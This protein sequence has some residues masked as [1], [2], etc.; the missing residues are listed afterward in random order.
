MNNSGPRY[1]CSLLE[2][3]L[4]TDILWCV[5]LLFVMCL[6][7]AIGSHHQQIIH[8]TAAPIESEQWTIQ[9]SFF[10]C[11]CLP[12]HGLWKAKLNKA[13]FETSFDTSPALAG[14]HVFW[15][16]IIV[17]QVRCYFWYWCFFCEKELGNLSGYCLFLSDYIWWHDLHIDWIISLSLS[18]S[19]N[20]IN[21]TW[22]PTD[23][24]DYVDLDS[25]QEL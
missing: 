7:S 5:V 15:T 18:L 13:V 8:H 10:S 17:L 24:A 21:K 22:C 3:R 25:T 6:A 23:F 16:M 12:G 19:I 11:H 20:V 4:N 1:K 14:F 2:R 9:R